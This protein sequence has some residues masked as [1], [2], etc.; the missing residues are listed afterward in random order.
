M[1]FEEGQQWAPQT[2][3]QA[4]T[5]VV[6]RLRSNS[7]ASA[8]SQS[9]SD[10]SL[11]KSGLFAVDRPGNSVHG[12]T[13]ATGN[14]VTAALAGGAAFVASPFVAASARAAEG[15]VWQDR[16]VN[17]VTGFCEG[18]GRG[19]V[20]AVL[21]PA[22]GIFYTASSIRHGVV[23]PSNCR[24]GEG[25]T[26]SENIEHLTDH[27]FTHLITNTPPKEMEGADNQSPQEYE[28]FY[29]KD[30]GS[31]L[32]GLGKATYNSAKGFIAG[33]TMAIA[34]PVKEAKK[35]SENGL[36]GFVSGFGSGLANGAV[37]GF[38][39]A[40]AGLASAG[41]QIGQGIA[42]TSNIQEGADVAEGIRDVVSRSCHDPVW[43]LVGYTGD[44]PREGDVSAGGVNSSFDGPAQGGWDQAGRAT[45]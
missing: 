10:G 5:P 29:Q 44:A 45:D 38:T 33:T 43:E 26:I 4:P 13:Q 17:C 41:L 22:S 35:G 36:P 8:S 30:P 18:L 6:S 40:A 12:V 31:M 1:S 9:S 15:E 7:S 21:V 11:K 23:E 3:L 2:P 25:T 24:P 16:T 32:N 39:V 27:P 34:C 42:S 19:T 28:F 37:G 20:S 14:A